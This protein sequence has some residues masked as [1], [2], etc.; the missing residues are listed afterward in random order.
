MSE[1]TLYLGSRRY[2][3]WS[4]RGW[5]AVK[6]AGLDVEE[7]V[8]PIDGTGASPAVQNVSPSQ[9]V[10]YLVHRGVEVWE[11]SAIGEYCAELTPALYPANPVAKGLAR[12]ICHEMHAGFRDLRLAMPTVFGPTFAGSGRTAAAMADI[13]RI[14]T[15]W[16]RVRSRYG[17]NGP[18]LFGAE[19]SLADAMYAPIVSRLLC[20]RPEISM[21]AQTYCDA[22]RG[23]ALVADWYKAA[24]AEP[25]EWRIAKYEKPFA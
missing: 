14:E 17:E 20:Y 4:L 12:S 25:L 22:V 1:G 19:F 6:L 2:S 7:V 9:K 24:A 15:I 21:A 23:Y 13:A 16:Q 18:Y 10:P 11:S 8:I 3:S 5:L